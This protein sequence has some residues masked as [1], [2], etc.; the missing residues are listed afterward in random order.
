MDINVST[1]NF[2]KSIFTFFLS[3]KNILGIAIISI[4]NR[5]FVIKK[6]KGIT[7]KYIKSVIKKKKMKKKFFFTHFTVP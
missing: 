1:F 7:K 4:T 3:D 6:L 5:N 2:E